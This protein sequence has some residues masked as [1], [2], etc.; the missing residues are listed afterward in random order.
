MFEWCFAN[1][2]VLLQLLM[3]SLVTVVS[4]GAAGLKDVYKDFAAADVTPTTLVQFLESVEQVFDWKSIMINDLTQEQS[5]GVYF[6]DTKTKNLSYISLMT[7]VTHFICTHD[8][9]ICCI[10]Y[11]TIMNFAS[12]KSVQFTTPWHFSLTP[13]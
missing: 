5:V 7:D 2:V 11:I 13:I 4:I 10:V 12:K 3:F 6:V 1:T 9:A 8:A